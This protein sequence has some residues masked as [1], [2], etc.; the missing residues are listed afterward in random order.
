MNPMGRR[1]ADGRRAGVVR[2]AVAAMG[3]I[4]WLIGRGGRRSSTSGQ[5]SSVF[6][7]SVRIVHVLHTRLDPPMRTA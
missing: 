3:R 1:R 2:G 4:V 5:T 6:L 7:N